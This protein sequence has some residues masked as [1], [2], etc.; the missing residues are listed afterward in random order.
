MQE[1]LLLYKILPIFQ[2]H[3][4]CSL[5]LPDPHQAYIPSPYKGNDHL[6]MHKTTVKYNRLESLHAAFLSTAIFFLKEEV[7]GKRSL[8]L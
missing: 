7:T 5:N 3:R 8:Y 2:G 1:Q 6:G 4:S